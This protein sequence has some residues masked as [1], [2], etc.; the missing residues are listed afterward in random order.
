MGLYPGS[1]DPFHIGHLDIVH[2]AIQVF[3]VVLVSKGVNPDKHPND[4]YS[5]PFNVLHGLGVKMDQYDT[6]LTD[7]IK[8]WEKT[9]DV[10]LVRGLRNG[11]DLEY[12]QNLIAFLK[13]MYPQIKVAAF[14]CDPKYRHISSSALRGIEKFSDEEFKK[15]A[16]LD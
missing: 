4:R 7:H 5:L 16:I 9:Y 6:L 1:F 13:G 3:D 11:A 2:Q 15:Y 12:E 10:T 8:C 14:Y